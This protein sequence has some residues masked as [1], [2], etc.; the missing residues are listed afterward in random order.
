MSPTGGRRHSRT[1][2]EGAAAQESAPARDATD[3]SAS[4]GSASNGSAS[5]GSASNGSSSNGS[6]SN[7]DKRAGDKRAGDK[8]STD[9]PADKRAVHATRRDLLL[10]AVTASAA[11]AGAV[12]LTR[13]L[14]K[15]M[16]P[17]H[18]SSATSRIDFA[19]PAATVRRPTHADWA[20]LRKHLSTR[21]LIRP[22]DRSYARARQLFEPRFDSIAPAGIAYCHS[23]ADVGTCLSFVRKFRLP[24]RVRSGGHSYAGWSTVSGGLVVDVSAMNS[25]SF[26]NNTVTVGA[27][28]DLIHFY[29]ALAA[30]GVAV[31][32]GSGPT[33]G[34]AGSALGGGI[35]PL[36]RLYGTTSDNLTAIELVLADGSALTCNAAHN[37]NLLWA[38][39][40]GGGG[41]FGVATSLTFQT[42]PLTGLCVYSLTWPWSQA[43]AVVRAW[44]SWAPY[45]A[46]AM[47]S[48]LRL[49]AA[50]GGAPALSVSGTYAGTPDGL[51]RHLDRLYHRAGSAP[52]TAAARQESYLDAMLAEAGCS[53]VPL[54]A[55]HTGPGGQLP[56]VPSFAKS[57]FFSAPLSRRGV[58]KLLSGVERIHG[59]DGA[60]G[61]VG[62]VALAA[63]GGAVNRVPAE[64]TAFVHR[65]ALFLAEYSTAWTSPGDRDLVT[66]QHDWLG[67]YYA[68]MHSHGNGEAYQN[69]VDP[70]LRD[71]QQAYYGANYPWLKLV[72]ATVDPANV[73]HFPQSIQAG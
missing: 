40:G 37:S 5:N 33:V 38:C 72:K 7:S 1:A 20:A 6:T 30:S 48:T 27:G 47:W 63:L 67:S 57:D 59:I 69:Y 55:C 50:F 64:A 3:G 58:R 71:W 16:L 12:Y 13:S 60:A 62:S 26:G 17:A 43:A 8:P 11:A 31:P 19:R 61:G 9:Q 66:Y 14:P 65:D 23:P 41:N 2:T 68:S 29:A 21:D 28:L 15:T 39:R 73:F 49:S 53:A 70:D 35:G 36:S 32:G 34:I 46:D 45:A 22:G 56:R 10:G 25:V 52:A 44:Q 51:A 24:V 42:R 4:N 18:S 54:A